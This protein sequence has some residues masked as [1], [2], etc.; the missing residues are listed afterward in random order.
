MAKLF[1]DGI[2]TSS[3]ES[4]SSIKITLNGIGGGAI[5]SET[6]PLVG[7]TTSDPSFSAQNKWGPVINDV[8]NLQDLFSLVGSN[9][10]S[11]INASTM[12]WKGTSPL[13]IGVEFYLINYKRAG[14]KLEAKLKELVKL[15]SIGKGD[16][17]SDSIFVKVHGGYKPDVT[18][19]NFAKYWTVSVP[20]ATLFRAD[21]KD[22]GLSGFGGGVVTGAE[23]Y[24]I[25]LKFGNKSTISNLLLSK[26]DVTESNVEVSDANGNSRKP[27][28]YRVSAQFTGTRPLLSTDVDGMF[29][30]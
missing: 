18:S 17:S 26:I 6:D 23:P 3:S 5:L 21:A 9:M 28:Y 22:G 27:L 14:L 10:A 12:C 11:W 29:T 1:L 20:S 24:S 19:D 16:S 25:T 15:A 30:F 7:L 13:N 2:F 4:P 8:S